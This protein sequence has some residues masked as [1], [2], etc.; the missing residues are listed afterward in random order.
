[1]HTDHQVWNI[2]C[3]GHIKAIN[4]FRAQ[5]SLLC[6]GGGNWGKSWRGLPWNRSPLLPCV[7]GVSNSVACAILMVGK[8]Q[9]LCF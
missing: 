6:T 1:M 3:T 8:G 2:K 7:L 4:S 5:Q 9:R